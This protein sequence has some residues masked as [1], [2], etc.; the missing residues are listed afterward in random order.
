[1]LRRGHARADPHAT[2]RARSRRSDD[3]VAAE[4]TQRLLTRGWR[5]PFTST[6]PRLCPSGVSSDPILPPYNVD[7]DVV[8]LRVSD[9]RAHLGGVLEGRGGLDWGAIG[10]EP[11]SV[12]QDLNLPSQGPG[13]T[14]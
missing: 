11:W 5:A 1:M 7:T 8:G 10:A 9:G 4:R 2:T 14:V 6:P 13:R 3:R 12:R